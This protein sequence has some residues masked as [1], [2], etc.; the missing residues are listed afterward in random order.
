MLSNNL[1]LTSNSIVSICQFP[2]IRAFTK[3]DL[4]DMLLSRKSLNVPWLDAC[5]NQ[6]LT[7][8]L[9]LPCWVML[10]SRVMV[11]LMNHHHLHA[12]WSCHAPWMLLV[13]LLVYLHGFHFSRSN[14][15]IG[16]STL[17]PWML[18]CFH[19]SRSS[20]CIGESTLISNNEV[21][22]SCV[23]FW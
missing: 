9:R 16:E 2:I 20:K 14:N 6:I 8:T 10:F 7:W 5:L 23:A 18:H 13:F 19:F 11:P 22:V 1:Y 15:C 4:F 17:I 12:S 21:H 3:H